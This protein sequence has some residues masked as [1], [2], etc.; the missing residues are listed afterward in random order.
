MSKRKAKKMTPA[1]LTKLESTATTGRAWAADEL[2]EAIVKV[3]ADQYVPAQV[4]LRA[5]IDDRMFTATCKFS[6]IAELEHDPGV[7]SVAVSRA[8]RVIQ[9]KKEE[10]EQ[11]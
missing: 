4:N 10:N 8:L 6:V 3:S 11:P 9:E 1:G 7:V 2:V 5:R